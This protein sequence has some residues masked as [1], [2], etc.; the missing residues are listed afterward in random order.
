MSGVLW[1]CLA[2]ALFALMNIGTRIASREVSWAQVAS[3]RFLVGMLVAIG[4]GVSRGSRLVPTDRTNT[5]WRAIFGTLAALGSFYA[6]ASDRLPVGDAATLNATAPIFVALLAGPLL[7]E[8]VGGRL[9]VAIAGG[10]LGVALIVRP[11]FAGA[12]HV[13]AVATAAAVSYALAMIWLRKIGPSESSE[14]VVLHFSAVAFVTTL[15]L[16]LSHWRTPSPMGWLVLAAT[17]LAGGGAQLAM[18][19]AYALQRAAPVSALN[20]L[21]VAL[22]YVLAIPVFGDHPGMSQVA[23]AAVIVASGLAITLTG[24]RRAPRVPAVE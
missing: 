24:R 6:L 5:W 13:A 15:A 10:F 17:G 7:G 2:Q 21:Q 9:Y 11:S 20:Y 3:A 12:A 18:T 8:R 14:A 16:S 22:T 1:M 23:G 19:R 4:V